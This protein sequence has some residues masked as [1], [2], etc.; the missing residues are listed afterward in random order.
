MALADDS[1]VRF[2]VPRKAD[3]PAASEVELRQLGAGGGE[4]VPQLHAQGAPVAQWCRLQAERGAVAGE[5]G[6]AGLERGE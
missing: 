6:P 2:G 3:V 5:V 1:P 4:V